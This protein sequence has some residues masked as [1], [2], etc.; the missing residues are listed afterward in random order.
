MTNDSSDIDFNL[1]SHLRRGVIYAAV[2]STGHLR[3]RSNARNHCLYRSVM[4]KPAVILA[5]V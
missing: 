3:C 5:G 1:R 2:N 4:V